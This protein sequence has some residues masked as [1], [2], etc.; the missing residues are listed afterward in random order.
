MSVILS[1][2]N[3]GEIE[4]LNFELSTHYYALRLL[5]GVADEGRNSEWSRL[6]CERISVMSQTVCSFKTLENCIRGERNFNY[7]P[8]ED[9]EGELEVVVTEQSEDSPEGCV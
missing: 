2:H 7:D 5:D 8:D 1:S 4:W 6:L 3:L 9:P